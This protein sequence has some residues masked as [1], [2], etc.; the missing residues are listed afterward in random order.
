VTDFKQG[1]GVWVKGTYLRDVNKPAN[2]RVSVYGVT[3]V[4]PQ[5]ILLDPAD[6]AIPPA[7]ASALE[8][9]IASGPG[10]G[11]L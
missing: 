5:A 2:A 11:E 7:T 3:I 1:Q 10:D 8:A 4:V 6:Y 9:T